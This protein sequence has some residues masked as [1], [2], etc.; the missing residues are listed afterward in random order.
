[1]SQSSLTCVEFSLVLEVIAR[2]VQ[3]READLPG[4]A[5]AHIKGR[6]W[7]VY[8]YR[9]RLKCPEGLMGCVPRVAEGSEEERQCVAALNVM[10]NGSWTPSAPTM[11]PESVSTKTMFHDVVGDMLVV[12]GVTL[13]AVCWSMFGVRW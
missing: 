1:M 11:T 7:E 10:H 2:W 8:D 6:N 4:R 3:W 5:R 9:G 13:L 12:F